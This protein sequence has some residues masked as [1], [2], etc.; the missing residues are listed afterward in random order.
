MAKPFSDQ[1]RGLILRT[2]LS[3]YELAKRTGVHVAMLRRFLLKER[4]L[5]TDTLDKLS[6]EL[7]L[8]VVSDHKVEK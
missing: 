1:L 2:G 8:R 7:K 4:G 6:E 5:T 3:S